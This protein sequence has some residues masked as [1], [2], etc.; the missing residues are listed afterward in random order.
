VPDELAAFLRA[1]EAA[2]DASGAVLRR[3]F[4]TGVAAE[5]KADLSPV[6]VADREAEREMRALLAAA[7]PDHAILGE[8]DGLSGAAARYSWVLDPIDGTRAFITGRPLFGTLGALLDHGRPVL[9]VLDQPVAGERWIGCAAAPT[10][11]RGAYGQ[12]GARHGRTLAQCELSCT[13]PAMFNASQARRWQALAGQ[14]ARASYGGDCYAYGLLALGQIDVI[15]EADL[16][17]WDWTAL[18]P[19]IEGAGG[20]FTDWRGEVLRPP[21]DDAIGAKQ[22]VLALGDRTVLGEAVRLLAA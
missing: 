9:G 6:T 20:S 15:A 3:Y 4:R 8:E 14:V 12:V 11:F 10:R 22:A 5:L 2:A 18:L 21:P 1:A 13:S 17:I 19:V 7:H 16:K